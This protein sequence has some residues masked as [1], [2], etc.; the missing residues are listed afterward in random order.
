MSS[1]QA[2]VVAIAIV[3]YVRV[4]TGTLRYH[5]SMLRS[6]LR[7]SSGYPHAW[8]VGAKPGLRFTVYS[9]KRLIESGLSGQVLKVF[10]CHSIL[11]SWILD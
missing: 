11:Q 10:S 3:M 7:V 6:G 4:T 5:E 1:V 8:L 2:I 9:P